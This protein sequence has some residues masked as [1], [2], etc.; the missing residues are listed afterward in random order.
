MCRTKADHAGRSTPRK[1]RDGRP[2]ELSTW[3]RFQHL[4]HA[5]ALFNAA[6][7]AVTMEFYNRVTDANVKAA[8]ETTDRMFAKVK[9]EVR[10]PG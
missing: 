7:Q 3:S 4:K 6:A 5:K 1:R 10:D 2:G 9:S 8:A